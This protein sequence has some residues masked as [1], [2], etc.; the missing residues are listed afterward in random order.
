[1]KRHRLARLN[2][3]R[4][5]TGLTGLSL[6]ASLLLLLMMSHLTALE[7]WSLTNPTGY[8]WQH[9]PVQVPLA[10]PEGEVHAKINGAV[11]PSQ[12]VTVDGQR[13]LWI[14]ATIA[15]H[16]RVVVE[17]HPGSAE[18]G[19]EVL[20][21][22][23]GED[24]IAI[25]NEFVRFELPKNSGAPPL[26]HMS[27]QEDG[28][29]GPQIGAARWMGEHELTA[30]TTEIIAEGPVLLRVRQSYAFVGQGGLF[31][32][33][34]KALSV[35]FTLWPGRRHVLIEEVLNMNDGDGWIFD[36]AAGW[37]PNA[38]ALSPHSN[39]FDRWKK[40]EMPFPPTG[41]GTGQTRM[42]DVLL[43]LIPR[44]S[45][46]YDD[47]WF[48]AV[49]DGNQAVVAIPVMAER[50]QWP[51]DSLIAIG[52]QE[53]ADAW[54]LRC[55]T[56][57]G[58]RSWFLGAGPLATWQDKERGKY[59]EQFGQKNL[60]RLNREFILEWA[61]VDIPPEVKPEEGK[62]KKKKKEKVANHYAFQACFYTMVER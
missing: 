14:A 42:G 26:A 38:T 32:E 50:W 2:L 61:G 11:V 40:D 12:V 19:L 3:T 27:W 44:W 43:N 59:V 6:C 41:L 1:M 18:A 29:W 53:S 5:R 22:E 20:K 51:H 35:D 25:A 33:S 21:L 13:Q 55:P 49:H 47:G 8:E 10:I 45:Q 4:T 58:A 36:A 30:H 48:G 60:D 54:E 62:K 34:P 17:M 15:P 52:V 7:Q 57:R 56:W 23:E 46:A 24:R 28:K 9:E 16:S 39:G 37:T 31:A